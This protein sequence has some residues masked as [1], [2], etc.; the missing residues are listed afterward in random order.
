MRTIIQ[1]TLLAIGL[2]SAVTACGE[3]AAPAATADS[4]SQQAL[5]EAP[6]LS[7]T[8][9]MRRLSL[10][11]RGIEPSPEEYAAAIEA[12]TQGA[13]ADHFAG[14]VEAYLYSDAWRAQMLSF[15][16]DY[17]GIGDYKAGTIEGSPALNWMGGQS[18]RLE[19]CAVGTLHAGAMGHFRPDSHPGADHPAACDDPAARL[20][21]VEPW[22][23]PGTTIT[24][25]G[26]AGTGVRNYIAADGV[27]VIDCGVTYQ[28]EV[29]F[30]DIYTLGGQ[31]SCGPNL[32]YCYPEMGRSYVPPDPVADANRY[33][34]DS[35]PMYENSARRLVYEEPARYFAF[36]ADQDMPMSDL[37]T[38]DYTVAPRK[39]QHAYVRWARMN[40]A[41][42][43][44]DDSTWW[45]TASNDWSQPVP[46]S[47]LHP[48]LL[49]DRSYAFDPRVDDGDPAGIPSAGVLTMLGPNGWF[50]RERI[51]AARWLE[52]FACRDFAAPDP[53]IQFPAFT[54]DPY[55]SGSCMHCHQTID[56]AAIHFKRIDMESEYAKHGWAY[57]NLGGVGG[58]SWRKQGAVSYEAPLVPGGRVYLE[59]YR[60]W[61]NQFSANTFLTPV[62]QDRLTANDDA[63]L[64]DFLPPGEHLL[65]QESDG[66]IGP[67]GFGKMVVSSG[68]FDSCAVR[69]VFERV[70]GRKMDVSL[71]AALQRDMVDHFVSHNRQLRELIRF[72]VQRDEFRRGI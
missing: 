15:G 6:E 22:W 71:D 68:Q 65:G 62:S 63:R 39:L 34:T 16:H 14:N 53:S 52:T 5:I 35:H 13:F 20:D 50:P 11:L 40:G 30:P 12:A 28:G 54:G 33:E 69:R 43:S 38:G 4:N 72:I 37:V 17:L 19:P 26:R 45:R 18:V 27:T 56:P 58:W 41:N 7:P 48:N 51:R 29:T 64:I 1:P 57:V 31:C 42:A 10:S 47:S 44:L 36:L 3:Q 21:T 32:V 24:T 60:R 61:T 49:D 46:T 8:R 23:A 25:I 2:C 9:L 59:P 55:A 70:A 67:L 66:T